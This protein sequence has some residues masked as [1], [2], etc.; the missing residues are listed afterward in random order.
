MGVAEKLTEF[1]QTNT[2]MLDNPGELLAA[3][4]SPQSQGKTSH[5]RESREFGYDYGETVKL[6]TEGDRN[7]QIQE[8]PLALPE[9]ETVLAGSA[10]GF[11]GDALDIGLYCGG[12][13]DCFTASN[14]LPMP[15]AEIAFHTGALA[16]VSNDLMNERGLLILGAYKSLVD[17]G[18][19]V[20]LTAVS[21]NNYDC[22]IGIRIKAPEQLIDLPMLAPYFSARFHRGPVFLLRAMSPSGQVGGTEELAPNDLLRLGFHHNCVVIPSAN[23]FSSSK[24][25]KNIK[26]VTEALAK[27]LKGNK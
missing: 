24:P 20:G 1:K 23:Q 22:L 2:L 27:V 13:P 26:I 11:T 17:R 21:R 9:C 8:L 19:S 7:K 12:V 14:S 4:T 10:R 3:L 16:D 18:Y 25:E 15:I 5:I 6:V